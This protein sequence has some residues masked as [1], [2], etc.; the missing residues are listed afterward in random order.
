MN[1]WRRLASLDKDFLASGDMNLDSK[2]WDDPNYNLEK[3]AN[4]VKE[5]LLE[6]D[7]HQIIDEYT[8][9]RDVN[10]V[11]QR[12]CLDHVTV[13]CVNKIININ[14]LGVG[15]S[16][17]LGVMVTKMSREMRT[18]PR[19]TRKRV[20]KNFVPCDFINDIR[21]AK[22]SGSFSSMHDTE[23]IDKAGDIFVDTFNEVLNKHAPIKTIQNRNNYIPYM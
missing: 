21:A 3:M 15:Q 11:L 17:H 6:E 10:G 2:K 16:D 23:D 13:N 4:L 1:I 14:V 22:E 19:T 9:I 8:R 20:Y 5:F 18:S 7:C 12:S